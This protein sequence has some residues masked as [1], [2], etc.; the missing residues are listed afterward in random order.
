MQKEIAK[1]ERERHRERETR[2]ATVFAVIDAPFQL[3]T[4]DLATWQKLA[5]CKS[6]SCMIEGRAGKEKVREGRPVEG[7]E[8]QRQPQPSYD[9]SFS[10][11]LCV[12]FSW[13]SDP[14]C[15]LTFHFHSLQ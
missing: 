4:C 12:K 1:G 11:L 15:C 8:R 13:R 14:I 10:S 2:V 5:S 6:C 3:A 7:L 9:A